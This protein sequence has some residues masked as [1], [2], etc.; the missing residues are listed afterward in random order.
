MNWVS[1]TAVNMILLKVLLK[2]YIVTEDHLN[3]F[4]VQWNDNEICRKIYYAYII[5]E[6]ACIKSRGK[7]LNIKYLLDFIVQFL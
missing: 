2:T 4:A 3:S 7:T 5:N 6:F 1:Y